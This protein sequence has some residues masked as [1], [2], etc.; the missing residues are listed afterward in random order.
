M[1]RLSY[2]ISLGRFGVWCSK[3]RRWD[4]EKAKETEN[5]TEVRQI[6]VFCLISAAVNIQIK[7]FSIP[8]SNSEIFM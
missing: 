5:E 7:P 1:V 3:M 6:L 2:L 4:L 8:L